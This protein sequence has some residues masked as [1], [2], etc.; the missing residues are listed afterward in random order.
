MNRLLLASIVAMLLPSICAAQPRFDLVRLATPEQRDAVPLYPQGALPLAGLTE[1]WGNL[2]GE[3]DANT[4]IEGRI[5]RNVSIP[6]L[7]PVLPVPGKETGAA[8]IIAPGGA[9]L[10]LSID[11]EGLQIAKRLAD[12]GVAA[13]VLKYR[14]NPVPDDEAAFMTMVGRVMGEASRPGGTRSI[15][16]ANAVKDGLRALELVRARAAQWKVNPAKVGMMGFSAGAMTTLQ[17]VLAATRAT[18]PA[19]MGYIYGPM[20]AVAVP[21]NAPP[22]FAALA[23]DDPLFGNKGF[24][25]VQS[26]QA[27]RVPIEFHGYERGD[28]GFGPGRVGTT[29]MLWLDEFVAWLKLRRLATG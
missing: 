22:M 20:E 14:T 17:T 13:F 12:H 29:T 1:R 6:T 25:I 11:T 23:L 27:A 16:D 15:T 26:W 4:R 10:S 19:F 8:V 9:F 18:E 2:I 24:A 3:L 7:T 5:V 21:P 28:H